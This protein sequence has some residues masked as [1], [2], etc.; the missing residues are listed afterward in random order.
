MVFKPS[1]TQLKGWVVILP[2]VDVH[3]AIYETYVVYWFS[4]DKCLIRGGGGV[5]LP[6]HAF[7][8]CET[9]LVYGSAMGICAL[10]TM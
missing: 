2:W 9:A 10:C 5:S 6:W 1:A 7:T 3:C 8:T 4:S